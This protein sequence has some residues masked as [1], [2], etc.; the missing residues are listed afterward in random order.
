MELPPKQMSKMR[1]FVW[2]KMLPFMKTRFLL[3]WRNDTKLENI[4]KIF[5]YWIYFITLSIGGFMAIYTDSYVPLIMTIFLATSSFVIG[6]FFDSQKKEE[7]R[8]DCMRLAL[9]K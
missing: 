4:S 3:D 2:Y 6:D 8:R 9:K 1:H 7:M 5:S